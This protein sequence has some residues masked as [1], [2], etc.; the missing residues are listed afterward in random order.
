[1]KSMLRKNFSFILT[2]VAFL[3]SAT[4]AQV[5]DREKVAAGAERAFEKFAKAYAGPG[6]AAAVSLNGDVVFEKAF[7]LAELEHNVPNTGT[8]EFEAV[9]ISA[10]TAAVARSASRVRQGEDVDE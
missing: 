2:V 8:Y 3:S 9:A 1:M 10:K 4:F 5:Q 7:G 6:C